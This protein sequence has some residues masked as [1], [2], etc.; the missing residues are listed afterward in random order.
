MDDKHCAQ[1]DE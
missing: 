1:F